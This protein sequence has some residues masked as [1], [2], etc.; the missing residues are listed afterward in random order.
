MSKTSLMWIISALLA[1]I[2]FLMFH[3][4]DLEIENKELKTQKA[5]ANALIE[6]A[7]S[8]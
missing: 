7:D 6:W 4:I 3:I 5:V 1:I 2:I 8:P